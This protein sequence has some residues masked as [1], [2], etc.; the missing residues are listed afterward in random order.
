MTL[1]KHSQRTVRKP[2]ARCGATDLY[3]FHDTDQSGFR[4]CEPGSDECRAHGL[5]GR[6]VSFVLGNRDG[7]RHE[8]SVAPRPSVCLDC[9][10][11]FPSLK[12]RLEHYKTVH[13]DGTTPEAPSEALVESPK[14][15]ETPK[16]ATVDDKAVRDLLEILGRLG[17]SVDPET[18]RAI[19]RDEIAAATLPTMVEV[20][21]P[22]GSIKPMS[23]VH[24]V[25]PQ[26]LAMLQAD[27]VWLTGP[28]GTGKST[29]A[30]QCAEAL[31]V[32][33]G[34]ISL[35]QT[36]PISEIVGYRDANGNY[37]DTAFYRCY[38]LCEE[39]GPDGCSHGLNGGVFLWDEMDSAAANTVGKV[40]EALAN[41]SMAFPHRMVKRHPRNYQVAAGNTYGTGPDRQYVGRTQLD[42]ATLDRFGQVFVPID[43][44]LEES[45]AYAQC[46]DRDR[47]FALISKVRALRVKAE[48]LKMNVIFSPR[49]TIQGAKLLQA[50]LTHD[51]VILARVRKGLSDQDWSRLNS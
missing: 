35:T 33:F 5:E 29:I 18:V 1:V 25:F 44:A 42:A 27:N 19:V 15:T 38:A 31:G 26:V 43:E 45:A 4:I 16:G 37:Q 7:T 30:R 21:S 6:R 39:C 48:S 10:E 9:G 40:N 41:G 46:E 51:Q 8:C 24:K 11:T 2:C 20:R 34:F 50:G 28:A 47:V 32:P 12:A 49:A 14:P 23:G 13:V 22:D 3:W 36:T 17:G